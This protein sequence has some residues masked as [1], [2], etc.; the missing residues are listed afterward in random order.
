MLWY[1]GEYDKTSEYRIVVPGRSD[2][3]VPRKMLPRIFNHLHDITEQ[4]VSKLSRLQPSFEV[5]PTNQENKDRLVSRLLK[6]ALEAM[7][8]RV[9]M[10]F[11]MQE[12]ERW[13]SVFGEM[14]VGIEWDADIGDRVG[15]G[16]L[17][18][19]GD[20]KVYPK[21][22]W[23]ILPFP[24][25]HWDEVKSVIDIESIMHIEEARVRF[26]KKA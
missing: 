15:K 16:K 20:V 9:L 22:P 13:N 21:A 19:V 3:T 5:V 10:D 8:R 24:C 23:T 6:V 18:R 26:N 2:I 7:K 1:T 12:V 17:E 25:R 14:Y 11:L 4:R